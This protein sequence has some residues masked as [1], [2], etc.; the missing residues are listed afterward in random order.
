MGRGNRRRSSRRLL[1]GRGSEEGEGGLKGVK[2][3]G[4]ERGGRV[5]LGRSRGV[6]SGVEG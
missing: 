5:S 3:V 4:G 6:D 2:G 1:S